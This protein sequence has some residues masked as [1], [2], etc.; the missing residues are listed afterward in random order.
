MNSASHKRPQ[1]TLDELLQLKW[2]LGGV[3]TLLGVWTVF[4][5]D[6]DAWTL[7]ALTTVAT[8]AVLIR[9]TLPAR[10]PAFVHLLAFPSI[11]TFFIADLWL[12]TEVLPAMVRLDILLLL[13]RSVSYRQRR[14]E[15][16]I[17]VLGLFL[18]VVAGVLTVAL[19]FA[20]QLLIYTGCALAF[21]LAITL[22]DSTAGGRAGGVIPNAALPEADSARGG[23]DNAH[24]ARTVPPGWAAH[25]N[26]GQLF[27][28]LREVTDWRVVLLGG[29]LFAGVVGI[30][31]LLFLAI[32]RFQLEN[33]MFL[34]R[35]IS[36]KAKSGFND[37][38]RFGDVTEI[39]QDTSVALS[40]DVS[41]QAQI[42]A[43]PYWRMLVLDQYEAGTFK[44][45]PGLRRQEFGIARTGS[46]LRGEARPR[47]G[48]ATYWTFYFESGVSRYLPLIGQFG[49]LRFREAQNFQLAADLAIVALRDEPVTM[50]A[51]RVEG[52]DP[53]GVLPDPKFAERWRK[54]EQAAQPLLA[55]QNRPVARGSER[56]TLQR[57]VNEAT[58]GAKLT[59]AA[60]V[61]RVGAWLRDNH[62]YTLAPRVPDGAGDPLVRWLN[63]REDGH[64]ELFAGSFVLLARVAG[65]PARVI[66]GFKG[67]TWN[68]YSNNFTIRNS[69]AHAWAEIFDETSGAW[70]RA[71]PLGVSAGGQAE[72]AKGA[73]ALAGR[74][75]RSWGARLDSLRVFWYRRIVSFDQRSQA[76]TLK[77]VKEATQNS[78][79]RLR[80]AI[81]RA[82]ATLKAWIAEPW[83]ARR[84]A[85]VLGALAALAGLWWL[86]RKF[87][88]AGWRRLVG[89][90]SGRHGD[91]VRREA[92]QWLARL[93][94]PAHDEGRMTNDE[95]A[96]V[97][98]DLQR[99]RFGARATW[100]EPERVFRRARRALREAR[101]QQRAENRPL[102]S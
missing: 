92:G 90:H 8:L 15:L 57:L 86:G 53:F 93:R 88:R 27:R 84:L 79:R 66:T 6:I 95:G 5:M 51:Y 11:V 91:P 58:G 89:G 31:A 64:C 96:R 87:G 52:F 7:M 69:D 85:V 44:L 101:R 76:E 71:D 21:L 80:A 29:L 40:V 45:S 28:R 43:T 78:G 23:K 16:Q 39:Q 10:V 99:L 13:Y 70:L 94:E 46:L 61:P 67:G 35:F 50:T 24:H 102:R 56:E 77:A 32:P 36:K 68:A 4:Y 47:L 74:M 19:T 72:E 81:E 17:I 33:S 2:L 34:D 54:R 9:P 3:L 37:T 98:A 20:A 12:T 26:W 59:A 30:S 100:P 38:I 62:R 63:S 60:F 49:E 75:D 82:A 41:N 65:F 1:L 83:D 48:A 97:V 42:P 55:M 25:A 14:D 73:A 18:I 22:T